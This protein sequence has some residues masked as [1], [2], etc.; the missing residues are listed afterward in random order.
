M[1]SRR[2]LIGGG[3]LLAADFVVP[4][5]EGQPRKPAITIYR[6]PT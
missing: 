4:R 2:S 5:A 3:L 1:T 6:D